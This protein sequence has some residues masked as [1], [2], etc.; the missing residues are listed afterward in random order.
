MSYVARCTS[1][2]HKRLVGGCRNWGGRHEEAGLLA[3]A[4][5]RRLG[6]AAISLRFLDDA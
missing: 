2:E 1:L 4:W 6:V 5:D 3:E